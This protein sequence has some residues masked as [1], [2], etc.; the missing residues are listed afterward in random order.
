[1]VPDIGVFE[2]EIKNRYIQ[3][4]ERI[5][6]AAK[7]VNRDPDEVGL[8]VVTKAHPVEVVKAAIWAGAKSIGENY[9]EEA[10][11]KIQTLENSGTDISSVEWH[12]IGHVQSRK[13]RQVS[14]FFDLVHSVD[15]VKLARRLN[16]FASESN[17]T[18]PILLQVNVSGES[19][20][21]G[22]PAWKNE[23]LPVLCEQIEQILGLRNLD[24]QGLMTIPPF[25]EDPE[26]SRPHF[27]R[28]VSIRDYIGKNFPKIEFRELSMGMSADFE[29]AI[30]EG[31]TLVRVGQAILGPRSG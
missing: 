10:I 29:V 5:A 20:K 26:A 8:V 11:G 6:L 31:A 1:M 18:I 13:A 22:W 24:I 2:R 21:S 7:S 16:Q 17:R 14:Q 30:Q 12:M 25:F 27:K 19:T 28:L 4:L 15:R 23:N 9:A 3:V